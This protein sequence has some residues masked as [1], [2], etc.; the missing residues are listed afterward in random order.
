MRNGNLIFLKTRQIVQDKLT[1]EGLAE[2]TKNEAAL[3]LKLEIRQ[4][5]QNGD[6]NSVGVTRQS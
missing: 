5:G 1:R 3:S 6:R 4:T 2:L